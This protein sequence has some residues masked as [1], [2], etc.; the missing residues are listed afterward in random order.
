MIIPS[1]ELSLV[2]NS[3]MF[4]SPVPFAVCAPWPYVSSAPINQCDVYR[5]SSARLFTLNRLEEIA[6]RIA[7]IGQRV[8]DV[9][10][11]GSLLIALDYTFCPEFGLPLSPGMWVYESGMYGADLT[12]LFA[13]VHSVS[14]SDAA[15]AISDAFDDGRGESEQIRKLPRWEQD[16]HPLHDQAFDGLMSAG[17][18]PADA[19]VFRNPA[20]HRIATVT[21]VRTIS[22][23]IG[24][25]WNCLWRRCGS[26]RSTWAEIFPSKAFFLNAD[27]MRKFPGNPVHVCLDPF[28]ARDRTGPSSP[29]IF[30][31]LPSGPKSLME[32]DLRQLSGR[33]VRI[34]LDC[35]GVEVLWRIDATLMSAGA[36]ST[37]YTIPTRNGLYLS[38]NDAVT[39]AEAAGYVIKGR[40]SAGACE[41]DIVI[42]KPGEPI[43]GSEIQR[44]MLLSPWLKEGYLAWIYAPE[45]TGKS[46]LASAIA[47]VVASGQGSV[48]KW[49]PAQKT[50]VLLVDGE[51]LPD[52]LEET[53]RLVSAGV[54]PNK[55][56]PAFEVLCAKAQPSGVIDIETDEWQ[57]QIEKRLAGKGLLI[58]DNAQSLM[59]N[60]GLRLGDVQ[61]WLRRI[62][63]RGVAVIVMDHT[64]ADGELQGSIIKRRIANVLISMKC[65]DD[66]AKAN[67]IAEITYEGGRRLHGVEAQPFVLR[68]VHREAAVAFEILGAADVT[69]VEVDIPGRLQK[70][71]TVKYARDELGLSFRQI[72]GEFGIPASTASDLLKA[73]REL[74]GEDLKLFSAAMA[75]LEKGV[76]GE[77]DE[78]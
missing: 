69:A 71:A 4:W 53:V 49:V 67:G 52:E 14:Y 5:R 70:M 65:D 45:K 47:Q 2:C 18:H 74:K 59:G 25:I 28:D 30:T 54:G 6:A 15:A 26:Y 20:G 75:R 9:Y 22:G 64:N 27:L 76:V 44:K 36:R 12:A 56:A 34:D 58:L 40:R 31:A 3:P 13:Q 33:D 46:W 73:F 16:L 43:P 62:C 55:I 21:R 66:V 11:A 17:A 68:R 32:A 63:Q 38:V 19:C 78:E 35:H 29:W 77:S 72:D 1:H 50:G 61:D 23:E 48:G 42:S 10:R 7:P 41:R 60:G 24:E 51:M 8:G 57:R 39:Q 37:A